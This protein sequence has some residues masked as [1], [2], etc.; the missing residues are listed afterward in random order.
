MIIPTLLLPF[1]DSHESLN[2][3]D[4]GRPELDRDQTKRNWLVNQVRTNLAAISSK[5]GAQHIPVPDIEVSIDKLGFQIRTYNCLKHHNI[6]FLR[7]IKNLTFG[8]MLNTPN[9]GVTSLIDLLTVIE[10]LSDELI[11]EDLVKSP[12]EPVGLKSEGQETTVNESDIDLIIEHANSK[13]QIPG[14][15]REKHFPPLPNGFRFESF[16]LTHRLRTRLEQIGILTNPHSLSNFSIKQLLQIE[17]F[18]RICVQELAIIFKTFHSGSADLSDEE[19]QEL[20]SEIHLL[21]KIDSV[22]CITAGDVRFGSFVTLIDPEVGDVGTLLDQYLQGA[23]RRNLPQNSVS[24]ARKL[25][26]AVEA[27][28][29]MTVDE[30]I[31][32]VVSHLSSNRDLEIFLMRYGLGGGREKS[33]EETGKY[34]GLTR[35]RI[36]QLCSKVESRL[37]NYNYLPATDRALGIAASEVPTSAASIEERFREQGLTSIDLRIENLLVF[38]SFN[39]R[40]VDFSICRVHGQ[41]ILVRQNA[42]SAPSRIMSVARRLIEHW[43]VARLLDINSVFEDDSDVTPDIIRSIV[44]SQSDFHWLDEEEEWFWLSTVGRNRVFNQLRKIFSVANRVHVSELRKGIRRHYRMDGVAPPLKILRQFCRQHPDLVIDEDYVS[45][46]NKFNYEE[47]LSDVECTMVRVLLNNSSLM[48]RERFEEECIAAGLSRST[49]FMYLANS[50]VIERYAK[51]V[52]GLIGATVTASRVSELKPNFR[53]GKVIQD[54][55]WKDANRIWIVYKL[56][57]STIQSGLFGIPAALG[58]FVNG[59]FSLHSSNKKAAIFGQTLDYPNHSSEF[60][61]RM[62]GDLIALVFNLVD[63][64]LQLVDDL[65]EVNNYLHA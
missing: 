11:L 58:E 1:L 10:G 17:G 30:E 21:S 34:F 28:N 40:N 35:E 52:Y 23:L 39:L 14:R 56:S 55:G 22:G 42:G 37:V 49:F 26:L 24:S 20:T 50:P 12:E 9:F 18:G 7:E 64:T 4:H 51:G 59:S 25:R 44:C 47:I 46:T 6:Q 32:D 62:P 31:R 65:N 53:P 16:H 60:T 13:R 3:K 63:R 27:A 19:F 29:T 38:G 48:S 36:R 61:D 33:L 8:A 15:I 45:A 2:G 54:F 43:G 57:P 41:R 5:L